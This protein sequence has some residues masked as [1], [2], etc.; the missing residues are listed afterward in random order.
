MLIGV[1]GVLDVRDA[2]GARVEIAGRR[3][4]TLL[5]RLAAEAGRPVSAERL[6][7]AVWEGTPP[8]NSANALQALMSRLRAVIGAGAVESGPGGYRLAGAET[9]AAEFERLVARGRSALTAGDAEAATDLLGRALALWRGPALADAGGAG[10]A[11]PFAARWEAARLEA[12]EDRADAEIALGRAAELVPELEP[13]AAAHP[14]RESVQARLMRAL[15]AAGRQADALAVFERTREGLAEELGVDPSPELAAVHLAVLRRERPSAR[16]TN[17]PA[18]I[19]SFV[20]RA[21]E[22]GRLHDLLVRDG[23][24]LV[25]LTGPG[26]AG[27]TR[28]ACEAAAGL[29]DADG[30]W[31]VPLAPVTAALDVPQA[32]LTA[33]G[34]A[35]TLRVEP[36]ERSAPLDRLV[37]VLENRR[38]T[39]ILDNCEHLLD[40]V[41]DLA[42]RV[43]AAAA[44]VRIVATSRE[45]LGITGETLCAVP[46]LALPAEEASAR[47][48][49][50]H[51]AVRLFLDRAAAVSPGFVLDEETTAPVV[52]ICRALDGIPLAIELAAARLRSL[53]PAQIASRLD[54]RF[55]LLTTGSRTALQRHQ[56]LRA[57]VDWSW[58]L[59]TA[60][61]R[62][63]LRRL[64]AFAGGASPASAAAI[65]SPGGGDGNDGDDT[66]DVIASLIDKSLV[67]A[68]GRSEVRY[69]LLETV[70]AYAREKLVE[71]GEEEAVLD[72]HGAHFLAL[73][74]RTEPLLRGH[75]QLVEAD[76]LAAEHV[77][78]IAALQW[79]IRAER[80]ELGLRFVGALTW[81]WIMRDYEAEAGQWAVEVY[82]M[83][84][85]TPP[86]GL[87]EAYSICV[88][89]AS[90]VTAMLS[91]EGPD[92]GKLT[93]GLRGLDLS[94]GHPALHLIAPLAAALSD[95]FEEAARHLDRAVAEPDPWVRG[96][97]H[98]F[99]G[100]LAHAQGDPERAER[101]GREGYRLFRS[102]GDRWGMSLALNGLTDLAM[103]R[104]DPA[105]AIRLCD[106]A[107]GYASEGVSPDLGAPGLIRRGH[108][109]ALSGDP[110]GAR[111]DLERGIRMA[112][113]IGEH[114]D[115]AYGNVWLSD[116]SRVEG[117]LPAAHRHLAAALAAI[118]PVERRLDLQQATALTLGRRAALAV[119][120]GDL[121]TAESWLLRAESIDPGLRRTSTITALLADV[122]AVFTLAQGDP[123]TATRLLAR[124]RTLRGGPD[125]TAPDHPATLE[126]CRTALGPAFTALY[127]F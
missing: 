81:F 18:Q 109:R 106:E 17:L 107:I 5:I 114:G 35:E 100:Y 127:P 27:K 89:S 39:L 64:S 57:V 95:D 90:M 105:A 63:V 43:L 34:L 85:D 24:R 120:D 108:A 86:E 104:G 76:R 10:F 60:R 9:D 55:R 16:R 3:L 75:D 112:E 21:P 7:D 33:L 93:E 38:L 11:E 84:G 6:I 121:P 102:V 125:P 116:L 111:A 67:I 8:A 46:S 32:V 31:F 54:D 122:R 25:T 62:A 53:T 118:E 74:E 117:D 79:A 124:A 41:A 15:Y 36:R 37:D 98:T 103:L 22:L 82:G 126:A 13:A 19:T 80:V 28:L 83:V 56:T 40:P 72:A 4:R 91:A 70:R 99:R 119:A 92:P 73:A 58:E 30:I 123:V 50:G 23:A 88:F 59:L 51:E 44:G 52:R 71:A 65:C 69:R 77:N 29:D 47:D 115:V 61:E 78:C 96:G 14:L 66:V 2:A 1:L 48:A 49:A 42:G 26:G 113:R 101:E 87:S 110:E 68:E 20:G 94:G 12:V 45:P 97:A